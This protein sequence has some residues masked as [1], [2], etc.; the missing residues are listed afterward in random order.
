[1]RS[2]EGVCEQSFKVKVLKTGPSGMLQPQ[3]VVK[4]IVTPRSLSSLT[5]CDAC[6]MARINIPIGGSIPFRMEAEYT[7]KVNEFPEPS[8]LGFPMDTSKRERIK[9]LQNED[10][11][12][13]S[14]EADE[15]QPAAM[16][17]DGQNTAPP[18]S[19][20]ITR[21]SVPEV[22]IRTWGHDSCSARG[23]NPHREV[24]QS[25]GDSAA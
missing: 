13:I 20:T 17:S 12:T 14:H 21:A 4:H 23:R 9:S 18:P 1:M 2:S 24:W 3:Q 5:C 16:E 8:Q 11:N 25:E 6:V 19:Q 15:G 7:Y 22:G 10:I